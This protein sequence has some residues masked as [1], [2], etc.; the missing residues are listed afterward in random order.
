[1]AITQLD[2][3]TALVV[4][5]LQNGIVSRQT[6]HPTPPI[7]ERAATLAAAFR[8]RG[9]PVALVNVTARP[10][11]RTERSFGSGAFPADF[12]DLVPELDQQAG[13]ILVTKTTPDAFTSTD[14]EQRLRGHGV[15]Q[16]VIVGVATSVGVEA[17]AR[18]AYALGFNVTLAVDAM[19]DM[20][21]DAHA[22]SL[23]MT[24]PKLGE[25]GTTQDVLAML[26]ARA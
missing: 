5:D 11:G 23:A 25:T 1:M 3:A 9:L 6:A 24:F 26:D 17:T 13:D 15:T 14:L 21:A 12:A 20:S 18:H 22:N 2:A 7:I 4:I 16:V 19:T 8:R 10:P